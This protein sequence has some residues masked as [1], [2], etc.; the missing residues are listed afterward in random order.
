MSELK[1]VTPEKWGG[2]EASP[3][4][5]VEEHYPSFTLKLQDIPEAKKW[6]IGKTY[7]LEI[8]VELKSMRA[9][10]KESTAGF[11]VKKVRALSKAGKDAK[12]DFGNI[13]NPNKVD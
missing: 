13:K 11:D 3:S 7:R 5:K 6:D 2:V 4:K 10:E 12:L 9:D 8:E 1:K